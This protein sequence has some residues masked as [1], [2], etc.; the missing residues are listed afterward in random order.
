ANRAVWEIMAGGRDAFDAMEEKHFGPGAKGRTLEE[1]YRDHLEGLEAERF[2]DRRAARNAILA[3]GPEV[4]P[5]V[6]NSIELIDLPETRAGLKEIARMLEQM[7]KA[8]IEK[9][10]DLVASRLARMRRIY[11]TFDRNYTISSSLPLKPSHRSIGAPNDGLIPPPGFRY[12]V[13]KYSWYPKKGSEEWLQYD[14]PEPRRIS[15]A[16]VFWWSHGKGG[17]TLPAWWKI[18][19]Q[20]PE[21]VWKPVEAKGGYPT[22]PLQFNRVLFEPVETGAI[23]LQLETS[24]DDT[25]GVME[26]RVDEEPEK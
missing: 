7:E 18:L 13:P 17:R 14:F 1:R 20:D 12:S 5:L 15:A 4:L 22:E 3:L 2:K 10:V 16:E 9:K 23:R 8:P 25:T 26:F 11:D 19:V 6:K 24:K 21:G